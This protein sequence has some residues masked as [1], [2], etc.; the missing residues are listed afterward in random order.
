MVSVRTSL[1]SPIHTDDKV[2]CCRNRRQIGNIN[3][4]DSTAVAVD[5]VANS[6]DIVA[7][8]YG[9]KATRWSLSTF[10]KVD[11]VEVNFVASVYRALNETGVTL[12]SIMILS[13]TCQR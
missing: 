12:L 5:I 10:N 11:C 7:N 2:D 3:T 1:L 9:A 13:A 6:V 8:V 4:V